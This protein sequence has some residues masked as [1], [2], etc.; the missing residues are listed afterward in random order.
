MEWQD[1]KLVFLPLRRSIKPGS[2]I[3]K[4]AEKW[5]LINSA[6]KGCLLRIM[7]KCN[8]AFHKSP[9]SDKEPAWLALLLWAC[10][11]SWFSPFLIA[12]LSNLFYNPF[13]G[14][15]SHVNKKAFALSNSSL[16]LY[17]ESPT[18]HSST[19]HL[20]RWIST[21]WIRCLPLP[22]LR[23]KVLRPLMPHL[24]R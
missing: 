13:S 12:L 11:T 20:K 15:Q 6:L 21:F 10:P 4:W 24:A 8:Q 14:H 3:Q 17:S 16:L 9:F 18:G 19:G 2:R 1:G 7:C 22:L 5:L 23:G